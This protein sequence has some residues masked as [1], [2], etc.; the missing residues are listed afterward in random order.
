MRIKRLLLPVLVCVLAVPA[1]AQRFSATIRGTV[2]DQQGAAVVGA[3]VTVS[4]ED[5][6]LT[7]TVETN[8]EGA[9][10]FGELPV[11]NYQVAVEH[12]GF[13]SSITKN[14]TLNAADVRPLDL[15]LAA[16]AQSE[17]ITVEAN[18]IQAKTIGGDLSGLVTGEQVRELPLN[19]RNFLQLSLLMPGVSASD[20]LNVKDKGALG[21]SDISVSGS[22]IT[23]NVWT[24]DGANNDDVGSNRT[25]LV[26][27]SVDSIEEMKVHRNSYGPEFGGAGGAQINVVTRGGT[28]DFHGSAF[29][30][31]RRD[32]LNSPNYFLAQQ[33]KDA[34][35]LNRNDFGYTLGGPLVKDKLHFFVS[36]EWNRETRGTVRQASVPT[37]AE[38]AGDFSNASAGCTNAGTITDPA[39]GKAFPGNKIPSNRLSPAAQAFL[40]IY[41]APNKSGCPNWLDTVDTKINWRQEN[42]RIDWTISNSTRFIVRYTQDSWE[43]TAP[44]LDGAP[45]WG[46]DPFPAVDS[47]WSEPGRSLIAQLN[48]NIGSSAVNSLQFSY[49]ANKIEVTRPAAGGSQTL[50]AINAAFPTTFPTSGKH[51]AGQDSHPVFW[52]GTGV[53]PDVWSDAPFN[54]NQDLLTLKDDYSKVFGNHLVKVGLLGSINAKNED[55]GGGSPAE[56]PQFWGSSGYQGGSATTGNKFSDFLLKDMYWGFSE[57]N[58]QRR[59]LVRWR[60]IEGYVADSWRLQPRVTLDYGVRASIINNPYLADN[61]GLNFD[62]ASFKASLGNDS[63]NG[64]LYAGDTNPCAAVGLK[65]GSPAPNRSLGPNPGL[66]VAPRL[67]LAWDVKGD[68]KTAVRAGFGAFYPRER[69]NSYLNI[70]ANPPA[71][72]AV[73]GTRSFDDAKTPAAFGASFGAPSQG[74]AQETVASHNY[75]WNLAIEQEIVHNTT[76]ELAYVGNK[77]VDLLTSE[78]VNQVPAANRLAYVQTGSNNGSLRPYGVFGDQQIVFWTHDGFST[79]H[80]LQAQLVSRFGNGSQFQASYTFSKFLAN[81]GLNDA[82]GGLNANTT[83]TAIENINLDKGP[84]QNDRRHIFNASLVL[85][86]PKLEGQSSV[87]KNVFGGWTVGGIV[88]AES[89]GAMTVYTTD[90]NGVGV[91][92]PAGTGY[93]NNNRPL[94]VAGVSCAGSG[95]ANQILNPAAFTMTGYQLGTVAG[96]VGRGTCEGPRTFQT[97]VSLYK[98]LHVSGKVSAQLRFDVFNIFNTANFTQASVA[99][100][101]NPDNTTLNADRSKA[102]TVTSSSLSP[103]NTFGQATV[104]KDPRQAQFGIKLMF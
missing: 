34:E 41:P 36:Q 97:D 57:K 65:G 54:N 39:T 61:L 20:A 50:S 104:A 59:A 98:T 35:K 40:N 56:A 67:G 16:G 42:A 77:G 11:G 19:G 91:A 83:T 44:G 26:Y 79:Y 31:G 15:Q 69:I 5:T 6:G 14:I 29:Y 73:S 23:G 55:N 52:G 76:L 58:T 75:Q 22:G 33:N 63:C 64:L 78:D 28:N 86:L 45:L 48:T 66:L 38:R 81:Q 13:K 85:N 7:K 68:G 70:T 9:Y 27:P 18:P 10:S 62:P 60:D 49:S 93:K 32:A 102:T 47:A 25:I 90:L 100:N 88:I 8:K 99:N 12:E 92:N 17:N 71:T 1:F 95:A 84:S 3:K 4:N 21:G 82:D 87:V 46:D 80:A 89:G 37:L 101:W 72:I 94:P 30:S 96:T 74:R 53:G 24:I 43:N 2:T 51:Y 103:T